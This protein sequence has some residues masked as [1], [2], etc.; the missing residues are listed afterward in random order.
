MVERRAIVGDAETVRQRLNAMITETGADEIMLLTI[1]HDPDIRAHSY[2]LLAPET[3]M[4]TY[5]PSNLAPAHD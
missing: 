4:T 1:A 2:Q 5:Q 3:D